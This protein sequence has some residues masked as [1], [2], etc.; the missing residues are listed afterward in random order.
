[1]TWR[2]VA[3]G[4]CVG[5]GA[6]SL[7]ST[8]ARAIQLGGR[9]VP[10][11]TPAICIMLTSVGRVGHADVHPRALQLVVQAVSQPPHRPLAGGI[12]RVAWEQQRGS[13]RRVR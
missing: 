4:R 1:M 13:S 10:A 8:L 2:C 12:R 3:L 11:C 5:L 9:S 6:K 7:M